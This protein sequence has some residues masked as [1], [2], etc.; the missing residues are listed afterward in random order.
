MAKSFLLENGDL[1]LRNGTF[2]TGETDG[3]S[4][5]LVVLLS[6]GELKQT[7]LVGAGLMRVTKGQMEQVE[8]AGWVEGAL[9]ADGFEATVEAATLEV[10]VRR[11]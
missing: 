10:E 4:A 8:L 9:R 5:E 3:Q 7:P 2:A 11:A 1:V 6:K